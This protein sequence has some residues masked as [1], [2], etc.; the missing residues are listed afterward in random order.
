MEEKIIMNDGWLQVIG[1][2]L[3]LSLSS[4]C[5]EKAMT[6][7]PEAE[8]RSDIAFSILLAILD[9]TKQLAIDKGKAVDMRQ[10]A[11]ETHDPLKN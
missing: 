5:A 6:V 1:A 10:I 2:K 3:I 8:D 7:A 4:L 11:V 9:T